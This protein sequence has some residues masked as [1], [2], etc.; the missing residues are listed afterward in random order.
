MMILMKYENQIDYFLIILYQQSCLSVLLPVF[1]KKEANLEVQTIP[2][3]C[4][5]LNHRMFVFG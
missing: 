5:F 4:P 3:N 2:S 1:Q